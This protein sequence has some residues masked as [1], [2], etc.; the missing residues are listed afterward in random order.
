M[1]IHQAIPPIEDV[2]DFG[3]LHIEMGLIAEASYA[4][5]YGVSYHDDPQWV[6]GNERH[7]FWM[8]MWDSLWNSHSLPTV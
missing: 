3:T 1:G 7:A 6:V 8:D 5:K 2:L 4:E